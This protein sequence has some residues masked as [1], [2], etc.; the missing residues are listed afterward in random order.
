MNTVTL[1]I[2]LCA[3]LPYGVKIQYEG[4]TNVD[5]L[6]SHNKL[7]PKV[8]DVFD[9][10]DYEEWFKSRPNEIYGM[11][12]GLMKKVI[13]R[14]KGGILFYVGKYPNHSKLVFLPKPV[15]FNSL[16]EPI[17]ING[18]TFVPADKL[19]DSILGGRQ[20][21]NEL[22]KYQ[23]AFN[24]WPLFAIDFMNKYH[25]NYRLSPDQFIPAT[26]EYA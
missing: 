12:I 16:I 26:N 19:G 23:K 1:K 25:I 4:I 21:V 2:D 10:E 9:T 18:E 22:I 6:K 7:E 13:T 17:I 11:K 24:T 15:L 5:E 14:K 3:R 8:S 20:Y